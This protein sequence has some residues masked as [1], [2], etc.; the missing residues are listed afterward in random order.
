MKPLEIVLI[1]LIVF[2]GLSLCIGLVALLAHL[3]SRRRPKT[4]HSPARTNDLVTWM[5]VTDANSAHPHTSHHDSHHA[6][7]TSHSDAGHHTGFDSG[8]HGGHH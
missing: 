3:R 8:C 2:V 7:T 6:P 1:L 5:H 4:S